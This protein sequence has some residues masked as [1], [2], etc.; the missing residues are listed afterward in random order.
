MIGGSDVAVSV[1]VTVSGPS[2][3]VGVVGLGWGVVASHMSSNQTVPRGPKAPPMLSVEPFSL[4]MKLSK[5]TPVV[6][7]AS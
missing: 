7:G 4:I 1:G 6:N 2:V 3:D 5:G